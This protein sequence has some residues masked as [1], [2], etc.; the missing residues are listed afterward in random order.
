MADLLTLLS[1]RLAP[2][3]AQVAGASDVDL[4]DVDPV[5]RPSDRA[6]AQANGALPLAKQLGR[7]P[8]DVAA[9]VL[10]AADLAGVATAEI[11]GPGF[12]NLT[13]DDAFLSSTLAAVAADQRLGNAAQIGRAHVRT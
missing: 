9:A 4:G 7:N 13:G 1:A 5:V 6:D 12:I 10:A 11:A 2:A 3:F 8:R